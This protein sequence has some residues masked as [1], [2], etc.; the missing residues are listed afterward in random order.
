[1]SLKN[2]ILLLGVLSITTLL[3]ILGSNIKHELKIRSDKQTLLLQATD[4]EKVAAFIFA[5]QRERGLSVAVLSSENALGISALKTQR[6]ETDKTVSFLLREPK[7]NLDLVT[8]LPKIRA[9]ID[10][11][12]ISADDSIKYFSSVVSTLLDYFGGLASNANSSML[13]KELVTYFHII[14]ATEYL[15]L[16]RSSLMTHSMHNQEIFSLGIFQGGFEQHKKSALKAASPVIVPVL[17]KAFSDPRINTALDFIG[18]T[19]NSPGGAIDKTAQDERFT[20]IGSAI[21]CINE[22]GAIALLQIRKQA[23]DEIDQGVKDLFTKIT[24]LLLI[25]SILILLVVTTILQILKAISNVI[26]DV[27]HIMETQDFENRIQI[28]NAPAEVVVITQNFNS[29]LEIADQHIKE[30]D[31]IATSDALTGAYNR[32][33][34]IELFDRQL[35]QEERFQ[36]GLS[37]IMIDID[38]FKLINDNFGHSAGDTVLQELVSVIKTNVRP[39]DVF[40]RW[41]G[42]EFLIMIPGGGNKAAKSLAEKLRHAIE[43]HNF[44]GVPQTTVSLGV[45]EYSPGD[46]LKTLCNRADQALYAAKRLGKNQVNVWTPS[47]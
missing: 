46:N 32:R 33:K 25:S 44:T 15:G 13:Y 6:A 31:Y 30:K 7:Y 47:S 23:N 3:F 34:F 10:Q 8:E 43:T 29:L 17:E 27:T 28:K 24:A 37:L 38:N 36:L 1:M 40:A 11:H 39:S 45:S 4:A 42:E 16:I 21:E 9:R 2:R 14:N 5:F 41:G 26:R 18:S 35:A 20:I 12:Q 22:A 19:I